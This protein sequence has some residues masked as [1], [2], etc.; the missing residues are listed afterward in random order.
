MQKVVGSN[1]ISRFFA[2]PLHASGLGSAR[3]AETGSNH[4]RI[5]PSFQ[6]YARF[7]LA[8][9]FAAAH[10]FVSVERTACLASAASSLSSSIFGGLQRWWRH[11]SL[12]ATARA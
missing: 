7:R 2:N 11:A 10:L 8:L 1:P 3:D 6:H 9:T 5:S 12:S 4:P